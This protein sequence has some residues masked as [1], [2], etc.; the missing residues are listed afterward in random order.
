MNLTFAGGGD[1]KYEMK[2]YDSKGSL[3]EIVQQVAISNVTY[4]T[5]T[6]EKANIKW[7]TFG[8]VATVTAVKEIYYE[9]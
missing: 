5:Y 9:R 3:I 2:V 1:T 7:V 8:H 6:S 4:I